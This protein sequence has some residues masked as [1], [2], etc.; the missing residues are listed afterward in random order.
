[1][2][3]FREFFQSSSIRRPWERFPTLFQSP[4]TRSDAAIRPD[5]SPYI[6]IN[7]KNEESG[8]FSP[9]ENKDEIARKHRLTP[10]ISRPPRRAFRRRRFPRV[11][12]RFRAEFEF[13]AD[14]G[15]RRRRFAVGRAARPLRSRRADFRALRRRSVRA[16]FPVVRRRRAGA[17]SERG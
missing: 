4:P 13:V 6:L 16:G 15:F 2:K 5:F 1:M 12:V 7:D 9:L 14:A 11:D 3:N 17:G 8:R 10:P